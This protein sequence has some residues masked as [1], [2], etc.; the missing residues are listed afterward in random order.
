MWGSGPRGLCVDPGALWGRLGGSRLSGR[1]QNDPGGQCLGAVEV[2]AVRAASPACHPMRVRSRLSN[3]WRSAPSMTL[4]VGIV[5]SSP[6]LITSVMVAL[7]STMLNWAWS[8]VGSPVLVGGQQDVVPHAL[9]SRRT[10]PA[11]LVGAE[12]APG[13]LGEVASAERALH[14]HGVRR[15][16]QGHARASALQLGAQHV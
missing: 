4:S 14:E 3:H 12:D 13:S 8:N 6:L 11:D 9:A 1:S 7:F 2:G 5:T 10:V 15:S 16:R